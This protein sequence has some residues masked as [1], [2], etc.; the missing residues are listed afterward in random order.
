MIFVWWGELWAHSSGVSKPSFGCR[1]F[2]K[3]H[4][5]QKNKQNKMPSVSL[6][7]RYS[8]TPSSYKT[9]NRMERCLSIVTFSPPWTTSC[10]VKYLQ[11]YWEMILANLFQTP[12]CKPKKKPQKNQ[13]KN[14]EQ[15]STKD[16]HSRLSVNVVKFNSAVLHGL[17]FQTRCDHVWS[18]QLIINKRHFLLAQRSCSRLLLLR[19]LQISFYFMAHLYSFAP[20]PFFILFFSLSLIYS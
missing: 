10:T 7:Q 8:I 1:P 18:S 12:Q 3:S 19:W 6:S 20:N 9:S 4:L 5:Q 14:T 16:L 13:H 17:K 2:C 11:K 15:K